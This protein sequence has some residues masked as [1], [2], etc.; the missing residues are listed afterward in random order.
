L[1]KENLQA[2]R[3]F[4][5]IILLSLLVAGCKKSSPNATAESPQFAPAQI[6]QSLSLLKKESEEGKKRFDA[7][8]AARPSAP[9][10]GDF[11]RLFPKAEVHYRYFTTTDEPGF[12]VSV[13]LWERYVFTMQLPALFDPAR[14]MVVGY[15]DPKFYLWEVAGVKGRE[16]S[17][18]PGGER[19]FGSAEWRRLVE[20]NGDFGAIGYAMITTRPVPGFKDRKTA[21]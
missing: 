6:A 7:L 5:S 8:D 14:R 15:G 16:T 11:L 20:K 12:D 2:V 19:R 17:Y 21:K 9:Y 10:L 13:D 3:I 4:S 1:G 18:N